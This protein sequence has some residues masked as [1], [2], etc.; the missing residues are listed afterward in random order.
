MQI[1]SQEINL[2]LLSI[3]LKA[4]T[5]TIFHIYNQY[6]QEFNYAVTCPGYMYM[7]ISLLYIQLLLKTLTFIVKR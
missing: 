2:R 7:D 4:H 3:S 6:V 1:L 5:Q